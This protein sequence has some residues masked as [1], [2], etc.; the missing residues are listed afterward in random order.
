MSKVGKFEG[1]PSWVELLWQR[2]CSGFSDECVYDGSL[3]F[4]GF[5]IDASIA[6]LTGYDLDETRY[7]VL[8]ENDQGFVS[9]DTMTYDELISC[10]GFSVEQ[11]TTDYMPLDE[12]SDLGGE[13]DAF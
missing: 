12:Y 13:S 4:D 1:E 6:E 5:K 7:I 3:Q 10:E 8:W 11:P 2:A 9:H